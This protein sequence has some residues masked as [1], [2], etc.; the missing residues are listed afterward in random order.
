M[1]SILI[2]LIVAFKFCKGSAEEILS[3]GK[4]LT[5]SSQESSLTSNLV[6]RPLSNSW[7]HPSTE[8]FVSIAHYRDAERCAAT[9]SNLIDNS[10]YP[11]RLTF[12]SDINL[13]Y[14]LK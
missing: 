11:D 5:V 14:A 12:G 3:F 4:W 10:K 1:I 8:L 6:P 2:P 13:L 9:V 7:S